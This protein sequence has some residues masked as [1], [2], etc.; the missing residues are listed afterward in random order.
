MSGLPSTCFAIIHSASSQPE[1]M[2]LSHKPTI[3][4]IPP[5][6]PVRFTNSPQTNSQTDNKPTTNRYK[7]NTNQYKVIQANPIQG[8]CLHFSPGVLRPSSYLSYAGVQP[9][10]RRQSFTGCRVLCCTQI[11]SLTSAQTTCPDPSDWRLLFASSHAS[12]TCPDS[13]LSYGARDSAF[14]RT[15]SNSF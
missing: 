12:R 3:I 2:I 15:F 5:I 4:P 6:I 1:A 10:G 14:L 7:V 13:W 8:P 9:L 11:P